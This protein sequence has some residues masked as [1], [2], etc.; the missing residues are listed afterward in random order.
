[1]SGELTQREASELDRCE[2]VIER[3]IKTFVAVGNALLKIRDNKLYRTTYGTFE[4]YCQ[5]RWQLDRTYAHRIMDSARVDAALEASPDSDL[6]ES[7]VLP[8]GNKPVNEAQARPLTRLLPRPSAGPAQRRQAEREVRDAW[9]E[10]S[11]T[12]PRGSDG[13]PKVTAAHVA[14]TV[15]RRT[16]ADVIGEQMGMSAEPSNRELDQQLE[17]AREDTAS[18][19]R[20]NFSAAMA[21]AVRVMD[22]D[23]ERAIE[24]MGH[25]E[26]R[27]YIREWRRWC[28]ELESQMKPGLRIVGGGR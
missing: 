18:R 22:F 20:A 14:E 12:A 4:D 6:G 21:G 25:N 26:I 16:A 8:I 2:I 11:R 28:D 7:E 17:Q 9:R 23:A 24:V 1:M 27:R 13:R 10:A 15:A 19:F 3:G 5:Q